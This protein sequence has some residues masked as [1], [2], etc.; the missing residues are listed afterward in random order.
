MKREVVE[1]ITELWGGL[2]NFLLLLGVF[3]ARRELI[4][5]DGVLFLGLLL[6]HRLTFKCPHCGNYPGWIPGRFCKHCGKEIE[7]I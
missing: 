1:K 6:F 2:V 7:E 3:T 5:L 4:Q